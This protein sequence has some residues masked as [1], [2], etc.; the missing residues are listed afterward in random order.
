MHHGMMGSAVPVTDT[1]SVGQMDVMMDEMMGRMYG[2]MA[3]MPMTDT[4]SPSG[5]MSSTLSMAEMG[6]MM[7]MMGMMN[8]CMGQMQMMAGTL[9]MG[10]RMG[11][12]HDMPNDTICAT[13]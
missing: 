9:M 7:Q 2:M 13:E 1:L 11:Q 8:Q 5:M 12:K 6:M 4:V 10:G 3:A